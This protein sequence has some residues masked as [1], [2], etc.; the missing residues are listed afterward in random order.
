[1]RLGNREIEEIKLISQGKIRKE[2]LAKEMKVVM[3]MFLKLE[4]PKL[5]RYLP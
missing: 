3:H 2:L 1:M 5:M 4:T